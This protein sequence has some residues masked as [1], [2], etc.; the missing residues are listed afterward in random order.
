MATVVLVMWLVMGGSQAMK[1]ALVED[2]LSL[3]PAIVFLVASHY[4]Q[5]PPTA[6]FPFGFERVHSL[7]SVIAAVALAAVGAFLL[8]ESASTL[9]KQEHP[10]IAP[11]SLFGTDVWLGWPMVAALVYS[12]LPPVILGHIKQPVARRLQDEVLDTDAMMQRADWMTGLAGIGGVLGVGLGYWWGDALAAGLI[13]VSIVKDGVTSLRVATAELVDG[14]PRAL[15]SNEIAED[16]LQLIDSLEARFPGARVRLRETGRYI[17]AELSGV[18]PEAQVDLES[19]WT[20]DPE[21]SW[22]LVQLSFVA[23]SNVRHP[24][25]HAP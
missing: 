4:E 16:A 12:V 19:L 25:D 23:A 21:R 15:G 9:I 22:R 14:T 10:T 18:P 3:V 20:G 17:H 5:K 2:V 11:V 1:T 24:A 13:A 7:A 6:K 8:F